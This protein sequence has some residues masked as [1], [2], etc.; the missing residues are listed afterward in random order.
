MGQELTENQLGDD[1]YGSFT[2]F[3]KIDL[4]T[5]SYLELL[6]LGLCFKSLC[7]YFAY[8]HDLSIQTLGI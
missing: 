6:S 4:I 5:M 1:Y 8:L 3:S 2:L 7:H